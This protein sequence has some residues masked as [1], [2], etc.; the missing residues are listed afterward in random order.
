MGGGWGWGGGGE[1]RGVREGDDDG[2]VFFSGSRLS[3]D[4][5]TCCI[6]RSSSH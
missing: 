4:I 1:G 5:V 6:S 3:A 2:E